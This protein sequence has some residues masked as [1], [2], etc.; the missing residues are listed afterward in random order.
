MDE[1]LE[2]Y[3]LEQHYN[4]KLLKTLLKKYGVE[5]KFNPEVIP[6]MNWNEEWEKN[7]QP[8]YVNQEVQIRASFHTPQPLFRHDI[9]INPKMSFG[10]GHHETTHLIIELQLGLDHHDKDILDLGTGTGILAIMADKLGAKS[11][12][13]TD[14]DDWSIENCKENFDL[15]GVKNYRIL[16]GSVDKLTL[17]GVYP[18][19]FA[20]INKNVLLAELSYYSKL[21]SKNGTLILSG[22]YET[23]IA[24][25]TDCASGYS[26]EIK[27][28]KSMNRWAA[29]MLHH[30]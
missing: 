26:L 7:F 4:E 8:V 23:D 18:I 30:C 15:N 5:D 20:N 21:L 28:K 2:A 16:Q 6:P 3:V 17:E 12:T 29:L 27:H 13:A 24:D 25:I 11:I 10:T 14:I 1:E 19:I 22:F 9:V